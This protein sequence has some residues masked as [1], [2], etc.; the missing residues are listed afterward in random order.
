MS[1]VYSF[2]DVRDHSIIATCTPSGLQ[3]QAKAIEPAKSSRVYYIHNGKGIV[4][5]LMVNP[6]G[7]RLELMREDYVQHDDAARAKRDEVEGL[8]N[9]PK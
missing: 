1:T 9:D 7:S 6:T 3:K 4:G 5:A 2:H 8:E